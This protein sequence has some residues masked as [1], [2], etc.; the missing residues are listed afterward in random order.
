MKVVILCG[1]LGTRLREETEHRPKPLVPIGE[2]PILWHI[3]KTYASCG[4]ADF[5]L[6]LG[7]KGHLI[8]DY[9]LNY[10]ILNSDFQL[11]LGTKEVTLL[12]PRHEEHSWNISFV[13]TGAATMTGGRLK[14]LEPLLRDEPEFLLTY[15]DG[16]IDLDI[17]NLV[18][19]HRRQGAIVTVTGVRPIAR[20]GELIVS[21][22]RV[23]RFAEKPTSGDDWI[24]GGY[25][26]MTPS[27]FD[28]LE[29]DQTVLEGP[30]LEQIA[31]G[32]ELA[33]FRHGGY[34]HPMDTQRDMRQLNDQ[35]EAGH[36]PWKRW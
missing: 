31:A 22:E 33:V 17:T 30:P 36:A 2:F 8:K 23:I 20:F 3:M 25:F 29:G 5:I 9:F 26:V 4:Y 34:W 27:I 24:N 10:D 35:W 16:V 13:D 6:A 19:F 28:Y 15:G 1:G 18:E 7:Y 21:G 11:N 32:G 12:E 14:Q